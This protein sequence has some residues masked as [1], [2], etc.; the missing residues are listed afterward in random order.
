[1]LNAN[2]ERVAVKAAL[3]GQIDFPELGQFR[4][5]PKIEWGALNNIEPN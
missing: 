4:P 3:G 5:E 2:K 1:M